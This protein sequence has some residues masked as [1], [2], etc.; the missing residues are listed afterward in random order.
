M[1][2]Y[3]KY[4]T[5]DGKRRLITLTSG[6]YRNI[7]KRYDPKNAVG[8]AYSRY[9]IDVNCTLCRKYRKSFGCSEK[10]PFQK[11]TKPGAREGCM[12]L[13]QDRL[14]NRVL[15]VKIDKVWWMRH[16]NRQALED[17]AKVQAWLNS[18]KRVET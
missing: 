12:L 4:V 11:F 9:S 8:G 18:F 13:V 6:E 2:R 17:L 1:I 14:P 7:L 15:K 3:K 5:L 10:C 16:D